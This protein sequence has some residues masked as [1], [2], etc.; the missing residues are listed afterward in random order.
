MNVGVVDWLC[1]YLRVLFNK[2][3]KPIKY[4]NN[5]ENEKSL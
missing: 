4:L 1:I 5:F 3:N 2:Y